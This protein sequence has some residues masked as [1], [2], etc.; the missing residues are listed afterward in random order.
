MKLIIEYAYA[1]SLVVTPDNVESLLVA[2]DQ[3]NIPSIMQHCSNFLQDQLCLENCV[4]IFIIADIYHL[5]E[6]RESV[7]CNVLR[8]FKEIASSSEEFLQ[9]TLEQLDDIIEKDELNVSQEEVVFEAILRWIAHEPSSRNGHIAV[10]LPKVR[11]ALMNEEYLMRNV[12]NNDLVKASKECRRIVS[13]ALKPVYDLDITG[14]P[15]S[16]FENPL[17]RPRLPSEIL[18]AIGGWTENPASQITAY[19]TRADPWADM[20]LEHETP[21]P[22][23]GQSIYMDLFISLGGL[24][25]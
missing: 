17:T 12:I 16:D 21:C 7:F 2:A 24:T 25:D 9:L 15:R 20:T 19:D 23:M 3:F 18:L 1:H 6:L 14:P 8:N 10:L 5:S 13:D 22:T 4:G 11:L